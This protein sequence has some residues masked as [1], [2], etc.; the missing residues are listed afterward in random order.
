VISLISTAAIVIAAVTAPSVPATTGAGPSATVSVSTPARAAAPSRRHRDN[1]QVVGIERSA[2][3]VDDEAIQRQLQ[4]SV[5][6]PPLS[7]DGG[8]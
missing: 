5:L 6:L 1:D 4:F 2:T 8:S 3:S 7:G